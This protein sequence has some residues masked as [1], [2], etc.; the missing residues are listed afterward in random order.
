[1]ENVK[2][3]IRSGRSLLLSTPWDIRFSSYLRFS[4]NSARRDCFEVADY[5]Y[6]MRLWTFLKSKMTEHWRENAKMDT[7][8]WNI[9]RF[10]GIS[11]YE[12]ILK[13]IH[14]KFAIK[15]CCLLAILD[16]AILTPHSYS[17]QLKRYLF[18][19]QFFTFRLSIAFLQLAKFI[20]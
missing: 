4:W 12:R 7:V 11:D 16:F 13:N 8:A 5:E 6:R 19:V 14:I 15:I 1:M 3:K 2:T 18:N 9:Q 17:Q 10:F 20:S